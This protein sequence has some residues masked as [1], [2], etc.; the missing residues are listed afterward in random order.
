MRDTRVPRPGGFG[1]SSACNGVMGSP[2]YLMRIP[3]FLSVGLE[4]PEH[5][6][7]FVG[8]WVHQFGEFVSKVSSMPRVIT[9]HDFTINRLKDKSKRENLDKDLEMVVLAKTY[10]YLK[11]ESEDEL[12]SNI[13][14]SGKTK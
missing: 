1:D 5:Q 2:P 13:N 9:F 3:N 6:Q 12:D 14:K 7:E 4:I 11:N 8:L 10:R